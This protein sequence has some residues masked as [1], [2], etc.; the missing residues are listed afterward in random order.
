MVLYNHA[1][2]CQNL[3]GPTPEQNW[4][5]LGKAYLM[6]AAPK[7]AVPWNMEFEAKKGFFD[8]QTLHQSGIPIKPGCHQV[9]PARGLTLFQDGL[10]TALGP[11]RFFFRRMMQSS[12]V[13][14][15][16]VWS[17][18]IAILGQ[19]ARSPASTHSW[20][21]ACDRLLKMRR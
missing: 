5:E 12:S 3:D 21:S 14:P 13:W 9:Y 16:V 8:A 2:P 11:W 18:I 10:R 7:R 4:N 20:K 1:R 19:V 6:Q 17:R 15:I